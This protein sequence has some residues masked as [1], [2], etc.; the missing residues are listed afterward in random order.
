MGF[1]RT[2]FRTDVFVWT[3]YGSA[4]VIFNLHFN[5]NYLRRDRSIFHFYFSLSGYNFYLRNNFRLNWNPSGVD[6]FFGQISDL[7]GRFVLGLYCG[8]IPD[9]ARLHPESM[10]LSGQFPDL[11]AQIIYYF[12]KIFELDH[13]RFEQKS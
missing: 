11:P 6:I 12:R 9:W 4:R 3:D 13:I 1:I 7:T 2:A 5:E 10:F 8:L